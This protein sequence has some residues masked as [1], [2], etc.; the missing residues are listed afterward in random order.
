MFCKNG[1]SLENNSYDNLFVHVSN[2]IVEKM[3]PKCG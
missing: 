3:F 1:D 2:A